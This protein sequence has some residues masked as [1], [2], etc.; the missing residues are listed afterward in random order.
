MPGSGQHRLE[1]PESSRGLEEKSEPETEQ[2]RV[3]LAEVSGP[4]Q[5]EKL[6]PSR[7][8]AAQD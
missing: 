8:K 7:R 3:Q 1:E 5:P 6:K 2:V 4:G